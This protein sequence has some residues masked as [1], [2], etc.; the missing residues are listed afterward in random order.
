MVLIVWQEEGLVT[1]E[2]NGFNA[3]VNNKIENLMKYYMKD[4][5][6][7][8]YFYYMSLLV[9]KGKDKISISSYEYD[10]GSDNSD[11]KL[12]A[13]KRNH[14]NTL[15]KKEEKKEKGKS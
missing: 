6:A 9:F 13:K 2:M 7:F 1:D 8:G 15:G 14:E 4:I 11:H 10:S 5:H 12:A 3:F